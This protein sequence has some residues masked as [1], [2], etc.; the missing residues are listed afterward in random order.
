MLYISTSVGYNI[1]ENE[2]SGI[3]RLGENEIYSRIKR[4]RLY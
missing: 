2:K 3:E 1:D 4:K